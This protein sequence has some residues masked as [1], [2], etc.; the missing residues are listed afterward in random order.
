MIL[1]SEALGLNRLSTNEIL[2]MKKSTEPQKTMSLIDHRRKINGRKNNHHNP[3]IVQILFPYC[4]NLVESPT[5]NTSVDGLTP[6]KVSSTKCQECLKGYIMDP[7]TKTCKH[8]P[9]VYVP[10][11]MVLESKTKCKMCYQGFYLSDNG[12]CVAIGLFEKQERN[13]NIVERVRKQYENKKIKVLKKMQVINI[14]PQV[15]ETKQNEK[16][17]KEKNILKDGNDNKIDKKIKNEIS[18][19]KEIQNKIQ[20]KNEDIKEKDLIKKEKDLEIENKKFIEENKEDKGSTIEE[21]KSENNKDKENEK[22][23]QKEIP[24]NEKNNIKKN[25]NKTPKPKEIKKES[26]SSEDTKIPGNYYS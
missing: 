2:D 24:K 20:N 13:K 23:E 11:C 15:K 7:T 3:S 9:G 25:E 1:R 14:K 21:K 8:R 5:A 10:N 17:I 26:K 16:L 12:Q 22:Q 4:Q 19:K 6:K 18:N